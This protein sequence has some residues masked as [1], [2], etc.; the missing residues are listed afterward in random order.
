MHKI[1][2]CSAFYFLTSLSPLWLRD[3]R[4]ISLSN[5]TPPPTPQST[6]RGDV[7]NVVT[8]YFLFSPYLVVG[9]ELF[10]VLSETKSN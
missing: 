7:V 2:W 3:T 9:I 6:T 10:R 5:S 8:D 1:Y 4:L